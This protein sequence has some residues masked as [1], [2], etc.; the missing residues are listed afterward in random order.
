MGCLPP[1]LFAS[2]TPYSLLIRQLVAIDP[3]WW[4]KCEVDRHGRLCSKQPALGS[5]LNSFH[6][7]VVVLLE[8][9]SSST[10]S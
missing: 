5:L 10:A 7:V 4:T 1:P 9:M 8:E 2:T 3:E 6:Q